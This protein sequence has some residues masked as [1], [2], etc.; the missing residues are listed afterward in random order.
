MIKKKAIK[1]YNYKGNIAIILACGQS[2][3][4]KS[5]TPKQYI[6]FF[7]D[8]ILNHTIKIFL[9]NN[10]IDHILLVLNKKHKKFFNKIIQD[11]KISYTYGGD[12]R[13]KSVF[14]GLK[15]IK[16][17]NPI[18]VLIHDANRPFTNVKL[19]SEILKKL[20]RFKAVIPRIKIQD[21]IKKVENIKITHL[22]RDKI[23]ALQ[24]PQGFK[25]KELLKKHINAN[26]ENFTDDSSLFDDNGKIITYIYGNNENI[27]ITDKSDLKLA[28]KLYY[29]KNKSNLIGLG[30]DFHRFNNKKGKLILCG[31]KIP[32]HKTLV[33]HSDG[34]LGYH[35]I[36]D[37]ILGA[38]SEGDIGIHF[39]DTS[40]KNKNLNSAKILKY[41][42]ELMKKKINRDIK[43]IDLTF[44]GE[45]PKFSKYQKK[46][47]LNISK[48]LNLN[49][50]QINIKATT[51]EK[52][53]PL[54]N[55]EGLGAIALVNII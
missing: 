47:K 25:F 31:V 53:G 43:N 19:I 16:R 14:Y 50:N 48:L 20:R 39:P 44:I 17:F 24:T 5:K 52:M 18:N 32:F 3:R 8:I 6:E 22:N 45:E 46:M 33:A 49:L 34:D 15:Y 10:E 12:S 2:K 28:E 9:K 42:Y 1:K 35:A 30:I 51:T 11:K 54:G 40:K 13:Q 55:K 41:T 21:T 4:L 38:I 27:K 26:G 36:S 7:E 37:G 23:F 29:S